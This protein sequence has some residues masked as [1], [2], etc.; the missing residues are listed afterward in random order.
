MGGTAGSAVG[1]AAGGPTGAS[2]GAGVGAWAGGAADKYSGRISQTLMDRGMAAK[3]ALDVLARQIS[4]GG[5]QYAK[6][7][8]IL[9]KSAGEGTRSLVVTHHLLMNN[10]PEYRKLFEGRQ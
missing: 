8:K 1:Y 4:A 7:R 5:G 2:I 9:E 10:D 6:Y 3:D